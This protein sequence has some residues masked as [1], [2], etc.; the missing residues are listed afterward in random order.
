MSDPILPGATLG[1]LGSGQLGRMFAIAARRLGYRVHVYSPDVDTPAGQVADREFSASYDDLEQLAEFARSVDVVTFEFENV[2]ATVTDCIQEHCPV[3]PSGHV[4]AV[5][6]NRIREKTMLRDAGL[7]VPEFREIRSAAELRAGLLEIGVPSVV[8]CA[9]WGYDGKGQAVIRDL[10][11]VDEIWKTLATDQAILEQF[12]EFECEVSVVGARNCRGD[13]V[14]YGPFRNSHSN[15][16]L[17]VTVCPSGLPDDVNER[18]V[19]MARTIFNCLDVVGVLCVEMFVSK[20]GKI[21]INEIAP[22]P[23]NS[24][25]L[26]I[27]AHKTCQFEQQVRA[28][29]GLPPGDTGQHADA[30]M[31]NILGDVWESGEPCWE[32]LLACDV[33]LHLYG[34]GKARAGRKMGHI[35]ALADSIKDADRIVRAARD[36]LV[37]K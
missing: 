36:R 3:Y 33:K 9:S 6:Q 21:L 24:G 16:I 25:H 11:Q 37:N 8:K 29:C 17:D 22:R 31:A 7:A 19:E 4:L 27:D 15:H 14:H 18:A 10:D 28:I 13:F 12:V 32:S 20:H 30:A 35:T 5:A 34:K 23:H 2:P 26:T 1:V